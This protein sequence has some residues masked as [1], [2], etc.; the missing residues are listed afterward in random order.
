[1]EKG[2]TPSTIIKGDSFKIYFNAN[3]D[4]P[5]GHDIRI[6][7][8]GGS[9]AT[10]LNGGQQNWYKSGTATTVGDYTVEFKWYINGEFE[11]SLGTSTF[12]I[13]E[14]PKPSLSGGVN[15][16]SID[17]GFR[18]N[19]REATGVVDR[20]EFYRSTSS[21]S[22]GSKIHS[23]TSRYYDDVGLNSGTTYYYRIKACNDS[24]CDTSSQ[25]YATYIAPNQDPSVNN[26][27]GSIESNGDLKISFRPYDPEGS[28]MGAAVYLSYPNNTSSYQFGSKKTYSPSS[29]SGTSTRYITYTK[30]ELKNLGIT[31]NKQFKI[32]VNLYDNVSN[33]GKG[34]SSPITYDYQDIVIPLISSLSVSPTTGTKGVTNYTFT[35]TLS[36]SLPSGYKTFLNFNATDGSGWLGQDTAG[37]H[38]EMSCSA[39]TCT[40][41]MTLNGAGA[42]QV[43]TGVFGNNDVL[44]GNYSSSKSF[45]VNE[46]VVNPTITNISP[47][48]A[49]QNV[50]QNYTIT[51]TNLTSSII[52]KI[53]GSATH[54]SYV[55]GTSTSV[56]LSCNAEVVG[57]K[58][59]YLK[60]KSGG[61]TISGSENIYITVNA[62]QSTLP[63]TVISPVEKGVTPST[64]IK[65]DSFKIYFNANG[66]LPSGHDI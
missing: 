4:L 57:S 43:R 12:K 49:T 23:G 46:P 41:T 15:I 61:T 52:G 9:A 32:R 58:R 44:Q 47:L 6:S 17:T 16:V 51:G 35:A 42:R 45:T 7:L 29:F 59:F 18:I 34:Y 54:C 2:V 50:V 3:G 25:D 19:S 66:D 31:Y 40:K 36:S 13:I 65:G 24:G 20:Y 38:I 8:N 55:S 26:V 39:T 62:P 27:S 11:R 60:D 33:E 28:T 22:L 53:E 37:G 64:I 56:V 63:S 14:L 10:K 5:S 21:G 48:I 1:V 30:S